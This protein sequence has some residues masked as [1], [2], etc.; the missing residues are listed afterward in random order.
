MLLF[1]RCKTST[2]SSKHTFIDGYDLRRNFIEN[3]L[4]WTFIK[5]TWQ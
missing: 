3:V 1:I 2:Y 5:G 4:K